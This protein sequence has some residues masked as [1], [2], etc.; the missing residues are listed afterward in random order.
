[1]RIIRHAFG[2]QSRIYENTLD[3][4]A[5]NVIA[6]QYQV[7]VG[8]PNVRLHRSNFAARVCESASEEVRGRSQKRTRASVELTIVNVYLAEGRIRR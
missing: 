8:Q 1:M 6:K 4:D 7:S 3:I 2:E 5:A